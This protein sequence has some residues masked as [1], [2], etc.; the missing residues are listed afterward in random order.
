MKAVVSDWLYTSKLLKINNFRDASGG[1]NYLEITTTATMCSQKWRENVAKIITQRTEE[2]CR[3]AYEAT[4]QNVKKLGI[5]DVIA[6]DNQ[7]FQKV[8]AKFGVERVWAPLVEGY[9]PPKVKSIY[10]NT[11]YC[12][13]IPAFVGRK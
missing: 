3:K 2:E 6:F 5:D 11:D 13:E 10:G 8:K 9:N 7:T 12:V 4:L 1:D